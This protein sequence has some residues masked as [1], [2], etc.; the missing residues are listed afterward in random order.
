MGNFT[1]LQRTGS[2]FLGS[3]RNAGIGNEPEGPSPLL[4]PPSPR[5]DVIPLVHS[6]ALSFSEESPWSDPV[7]G[8]E[9]VS[10]L[11]GGDVCPKEGGQVSPLCT[12]LNLQTP[13][14]PQPVRL[15][16]AWELS[17]KGKPWRRHWAHP[18]PAATHV[19]RG[20]Y[21]PH[22]TYCKHVNPAAAHLGV[23]DINIKAVNICT[24]GM[25]NTIWPPPLGLISGL[26][27][28]VDGEDINEA[29]ELPTPYNRT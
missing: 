9:V 14:F 24:K 1:G 7:G 6:S 22:S 12:E 5:G 26:N 16:P 13:R 27:M 4:S 25:F 29:T 19:R 2:A 15:T 17:L 11:E 23:L 21:T 8:R 18:L 28:Q 3:K 10:S 20:V